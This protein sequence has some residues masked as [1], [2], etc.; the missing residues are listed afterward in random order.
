MQEIPLIIV[1]DPDE[2][3]A[4]EVLVD[5]TVDGHP[6]RFLL[7]TGAARSQV[8]ADPYT[9]TLPVVSTEDSHGAAAAVSNELVRVGELSVGPLRARNLAVNRVPVNQPGARNLIGMDLLADVCCGIDLAERK[10]RIEPTPHPDAALPLLMDARNHCYVELSWPA[11]Q[12]RAQACFDTGAGLTVV[13]QGFIDKHPALFER[14]GAS[15]GMDSTGAQVE[16]PLYVMAGAVIGG[17][18]FAGDTVAALDL[19][20]VNATLDLPMDLIL[21]YPTIRQARWLFDF[22]A[23]RWSSRAVGIRPLQFQHRGQA[24][25]RER[26]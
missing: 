25:R 17:A 13:D 15:T 24:Q 2:P 11:T 19:A 22:P 16:T 18:Q 10:L 21:G 26:A 20:P 3:H 23:R 1:P 14:A 4:A 6:R 5:G 8:V 12:I 9:A 7:D